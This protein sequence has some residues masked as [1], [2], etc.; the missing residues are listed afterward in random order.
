[1]SSD[2]WEYVLEQDGGGR[3]GE[4]VRTLRERGD[5]SPHAM[6]FP[7]PEEIELLCELVGR[8]Q[9]LEIAHGKL[10]G[11]LQQLGRK[12]EGKGEDRWVLVRHAHRGIEFLDTEGDWHADLSGAR[13]FSTGAEAREEVRS[14]GEMALEHY[15]ARALRDAR[16]TCGVEWH[17]FGCEC[18]GAGGAR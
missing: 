12:L 6:G 4:L 10:E 16:K 7:F 13:W 15:Q 3:A 11:E 18:D 5:R 9:E 2:R 17:A 14:P 8:V 1:M